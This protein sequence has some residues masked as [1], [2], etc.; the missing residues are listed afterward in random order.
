MS[1][2]SQKLGRIRGAMNLVFTEVL[3]GL[4]EYQE[5][6]SAT[7]IK[8]IFRTKSLYP[9]KHLVFTCVSGCFGTTL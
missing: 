2:D 4:K 3:T 5:F 8:K 6:K 7:E 1:R 9:D